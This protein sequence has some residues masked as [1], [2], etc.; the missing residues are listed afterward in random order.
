MPAVEADD[1]TIE[2][3]V[4][5]TRAI[6]SIPEGEDR[7]ALI[8]RRGRLLDAIAMR[9]H[10]RHDPTGAVVVLYPASW[11]VD[12]TVDVDRIDDI[13]EAIERPLHDRPDEDAW[14]EIHEHNMAIARAVERRYGPVHGETIRAL[15]T[16]L[17]NHHL[18]RIDEVTPDQLE[19]F[20]EDY[21]ERN[22]W[23]TGEQ[24]ELLGRSIDMLDR[25]V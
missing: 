23:P 10:V 18:C 16:Y 14:G 22:A 8:D 15:G 11:V 13:D 12:G 9:C 5:L 1:R 17:S 7:A 21:F 20:T 3:I 4:E 19:T 2:R 6:E 25:V 24:L